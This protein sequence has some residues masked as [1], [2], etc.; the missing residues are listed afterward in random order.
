MHSYFNVSLEFNQ[1]IF[2]NKINETIMKRSKGYVCVVDANVLTIAQTNLYYRDI[3]NSS[4]VNTCD[5]SSISF[6][7]GWIHKKKFCALTGPDIFS[8]YIEKYY[9]QLLLG[10]TIEISNTIKNILESKSISSSHLNVMPLPFLPVE[11]FDYLSIAKEINKLNPDIIWVSLGAPKQEL[12]M[13]KLLPYLTSGVMFG[14]GAAFRFY[15][16]D[17]RMP[18]INIRGLKFVWLNR[19]FREPKKVIKR[20]IPAVLI[21]PKLYLEEKMRYKNLNTD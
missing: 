7:A 20:A 17:L 12:F 4:I 18:K 15:L 10:C 5:G 16:G 3:I 6:L 14:I 8:N 11:K 1:Q 19:L 2:Y 9:K 21:V 13:H